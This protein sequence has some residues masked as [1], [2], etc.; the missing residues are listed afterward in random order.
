MRGQRSYPQI[1]QITQIRLRAE[2]RANWTSTDSNSLDPQRSAL[3]SLPSALSPQRS[4]LSSLP[5][6]LCPYPFAL[7]LLQDG[8]LRTQHDEMP[9]LEGV[10]GFGAQ[11][12]VCSLDVQLFRNGPL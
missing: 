4:A 12:H 6:A 2:G 10:D 11:A 8:R 9:A 1:T 3:S 7:C 5:S